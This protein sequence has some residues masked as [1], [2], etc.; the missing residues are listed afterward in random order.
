MCAMEVT[1]EH[2]AQLVGCIPLRGDASSQP[3]CCSLCFSAVLP[4]ER[5]LGPSGGLA[6]PGARSHHIL[7][8]GGL[9]VLVPRHVLHTRAFLSSSVCSAAEQG[10]AGD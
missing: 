10:S 5:G 2:S 6:A 7:G 1:R 8:C 4:P 3:G 9:G